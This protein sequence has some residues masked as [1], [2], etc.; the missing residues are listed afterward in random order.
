M[1]KAHPHATAAVRANT[2]THMGRWNMDAFV[3]LIKDGVKL[4]IIQRLSLY[5]GSD[6]IFYR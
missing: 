2:T 1:Y 4:A 6:L 5:L 3:T